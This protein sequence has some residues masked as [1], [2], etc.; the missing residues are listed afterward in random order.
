MSPEEMQRMQEE[1]CPFC[2]IIKGEIPS[3]KIFEDD[4]HLAILDINPANEGHIL[5]LPKKHYQ[6]MPQMPENE[7]S[8]MFLLSKKLSK[9][10][11]QTYQSGGTSVF[12]ANGGVAGQRAPHF[13]MHV[14]PRLEND[15]LFNLP[16]KELNGN[17]LNSVQKTLISHL[18]KMFG[19]KVVEDK[20]VENKKVLESIKKPESDNSKELENISKDLPKKG[21]ADLDNISNILLK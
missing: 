13:M 12:V 4:N 17:D 11:L 1:Q 20:P 9:I 2:K 3:Q 10:L 19:K 5:L 18:S 15:G 7:L 14:I 16:K 6:I 8:K 21:D